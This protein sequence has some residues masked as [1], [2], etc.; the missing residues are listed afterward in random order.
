MFIEKNLQ[1][2][3]VIHHALRHFIVNR[4]EFKTVIAGFP[5]FLDWGRDTLI[6]LRGLID[7]GFENEASDILRQ[8]AKF[9]K[10]GT[11]PNMIRGNDDS[12]RDTADAPLWFFVAVHDFI[13]KFKSNE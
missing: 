6:V 8:F 3:T 4:D 7:D 12:N 13:R 2:D 1:V 10:Q 5:W 9:E 11:L